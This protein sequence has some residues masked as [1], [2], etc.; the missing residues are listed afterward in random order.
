MTATQTPAAGLTPRPAAG[1][2]W[3]LLGDCAQVDP[4]LWFPESSQPSAPAK[5]ICLGCEV[6]VQC[7]EYALAHGERGIWGGTNEGQRR[8]IRRTRDDATRRNAAAE[9]AAARREEIA[10]LL[11]FRWSCERIA[12]RLGMHPTSVRDIARNLAAA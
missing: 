7:L 12:E 6:R 4:D 8:A 1:T 2:N 10:H 11:S 3:K 9:A 5:A